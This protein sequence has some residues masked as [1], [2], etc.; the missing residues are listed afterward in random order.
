MLYR[1]ILTL[2]L[3]LPSTALTQ[4]SDTLR[5]CTYNLLSFDEKDTALVDDYLMILNAI[6][7]QVLT[8]QEITS[9]KGYEL[10]TREIA[11]RLDIPLMGTNIE[12]DAGSN[13]YSAGFYDPTHFTYLD[14][15]IDPATPASQIT[16]NL[17]HT[18]SDRQIAVMSLYWKAGNTAGDRTTRVGNAETVRSRCKEISPFLPDIIATGDLNVYTADEDAYQNLLFDQEGKRLLYDPINRPGDWSNNQEFADLHTQSTRVEQFGGGFGGGLDDRF[19]QILLSGS[20]L[21]LYVPGSYTTF[22]NDGKH[23]DSSV[24]SP[25]NSA[26]SPEVAEALYNASDHLPV[27]LD[28]AIPLPSSSIYL[29]EK[30]PEC[31]VKSVGSEKLIFA[32]RDCIP[33]ELRV[34]DM[35]GKEVFHPTSIPAMIGGRNLMITWETDGMPSGTYLWQCQTTEGEFS[36]K[37]QIGTF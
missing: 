18:E 14:K 17:Y 26:V 7:P 15:W 4:S 32:F 12:F 36:G 19:D 37:V 24:N 29:D 22:G 30:K 13:S 2:S 33:E 9:I 21:D 28:L 8:V 34:V 6:R 23:L 1:V 16:M 31:R 25:G 5:F 35:E 3:V 11:A 10:F 20:L 27:Y